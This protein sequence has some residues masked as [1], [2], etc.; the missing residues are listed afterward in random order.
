MAEDTT[1]PP[2]ETTP[3]VAATATPNTPV[4]TPQIPTEFNATAAFEKALEE[5]D[6]G[7]T[8]TPAAAKPVENKPAEAAKP[9]E[10]PAS[11]EQRP[12]TDAKP[13]DTKPE[14]VV[15][16]DELQPLPHDKP[17]TQAR[18]KTLHG[19]WRT[20][21]EKATSLEAK[22]RELEEKTK[23]TPAQT[24]DLDALKKQAD[25]ARAKA[26]A[27]EKLAKETEDK[28]LPYRRQ[29]EVEKSP[30]VE[31]R[32]VKPVKAAEETIAATLK[33]YGLGEATL[34]EIEKHGGLAAFTK[35]KKT[36]TL[37]DAEGEPVTVTA[38]QVVNEWLGKMDFAD[39]EKI[40]SLV[41]EQEKLSLQ[42]GLY[43]D[44]EKAKARE[45]FDGLSKKQQE[46]QAAFKAQQETHAKEV[47]KWIDTQ[48]ANDEQL[49][50]VDGPDKADRAEARSRLLKYLG[51]ADRD[52]LLNAAKDAALL[53]IVRKQLG[54]KDAEIAAL[55]EQ[56]KAKEAELDKTKTAGAAVPA[57]AGRLGSGAAPSQAKPEMNL[58]ALL[59]R[60][61][62]AALGQAIDAG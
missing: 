49:K 48:F 55:K 13:T 7:G 32:F 60:D 10:T 41:G 45:Y 34:K 26:E 56:L 12:V 54:S 43:I 18:I 14:D 21:E 57:R 6:K 31:E 23:L 36:Y 42:R 19:K 24:A 46:E 62:G 37:K 8:E 58:A 33:N 28:Y 29:Y 50:D 40:R 47:A 27:A 53:P 39:A 51:G 35:S 38:S 20:A 5:A 59:N 2:A 9:V 11:T 30:E 44:A 17:K 52:T 1:T 22:V 61:G 25:E 16:D 15:S 4:E 3:P